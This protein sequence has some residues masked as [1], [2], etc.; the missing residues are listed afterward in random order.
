MPQSLQFALG[1]LTVSVEGIPDE[2]DP[3]MFAVDLNVWP[4][5]ADGVEVDTFT[6]A[7]HAL[8]GTETFTGI[9]PDNEFSV[10]VETRSSAGDA[11]GELQLYMSG[12]TSPERKRVLRLLALGE[13]GA[14]ALELRERADRLDAEAGET[15]VDTL[16][17]ALTDRASELRAE[18]DLLTTPA[19][20][21]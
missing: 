21:A 20:V 1:P 17:L 18:A 7:F 4:H 3:R 14:R 10:K 11:A 2:V 6:S 8:G 12:I 13:D 15:P 5:N 9:D 16:A 19:E